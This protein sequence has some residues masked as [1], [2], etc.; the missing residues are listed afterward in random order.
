MPSDAGDISLEDLRGCNDFS[1]PAG[2]PY[3]R[4]LLLERALLAARVDIEAGQAYGTAC[5][6]G[7]GR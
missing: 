5:L 2:L 6:R 4:L 3:R 1:V 7:K